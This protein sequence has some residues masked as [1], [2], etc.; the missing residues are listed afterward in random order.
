MNI[1]GIGQYI[2]L[3]SSAMKLK[4]MDC[5]VASSGG[6]L[7]E[8]LKKIGIKHKYI[9]IK[10]KFEFSPKVFM[11]SSNIAN[12]IR[13][14]KVDIVHAHTRVSQVASILAS[15][16]TGTHY[17]STCHGFFKPRL[18]RR[19]FDTWGEKVVAISEPVRT[20]LEMDF[21]IH[22]ARIE[23]IHNG[24]DISEF[25]KDYSGDE[26]AKIKRS[27][28]LEEGPVIGTMGRLSLV[29]GQRFLIEA[30][31]YVIS[32]ET[33][34]QCLIIGSGPE[35]SALKAFTKDIGVESRVKFVGSIYKDIA[36]YLACMDIFVL[37]SIK[38]GLGIA[39]L[40]AMAATL[41]C[42]A[43]DIGGISDIVKNQ[44]NGILAPVANGRAIGDAILRLLNDKAFS[45]ELA[46]KAKEFVRE[47]FSLNLMAE[48]MDRLYKGIINGKH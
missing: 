28:G 42:I 34:A 40:E 18:F 10:T 14:E 5:I 11:A 25:S 15:H 30:M 31:K 24:V 19:L 35:E 44:E 27:I 47:K 46:R 6:D 29:K 26:I 13:E 12:I 17:I 23:L 4:G 43:S 39:L 21:A 22:P 36:S 8:E 1:G 2:L 20:H 9:D 3:L 33:S 41:P 48:K 37:P 7:E 38:E 45:L 32:K 16:S